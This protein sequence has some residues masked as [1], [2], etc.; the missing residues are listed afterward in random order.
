MYGKPCLF[1]K[2][3]LLFPCLSLTSRGKESIT[4]LSRCLS[5][6]GISPSGLSRRTNSMEV[7]LFLAPVIAA[8]KAI[9]FLLYKRNRSLCSSKPKQRSWRAYSRGLAFLPTQVTYVIN[10]IFNCCL[11]QR[12]FIPLLYNGHFPPK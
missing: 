9:R 3:S 2:A 12:I 8:P 5:S 6:M 1:D 7:S 4:R 11:F 10:C